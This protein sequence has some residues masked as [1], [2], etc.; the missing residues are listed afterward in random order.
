MGAAAAGERRRRLRTPDPA[1]ALP[2]ASGRVRASGFFFSRHPDP[3]PLGPVSPPGART[4]RTL[5][6]GAAALASPPPC[7]VPGEQRVRGAGGLRHPRRG[8]RAAPVAVAITTPVGTGAAVP[9]WSQIL[10]EGRSRLPFVARSLLAKEGGWGKVFLP[11]CWPYWHG[12][13][14]SHC[15]CGIAVPRRFHVPT[16]LGSPLMSG[17]EPLARPWRRCLCLHYRWPVQL[18][19]FQ[20]PWPGA[21]AHA[22]LSPICAVLV[23][24]S[25]QHVCGAGKWGH[26]APASTSAGVFHSAGWAG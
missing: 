3:Q 6:T 20:E 2:L 25:K 7:P 13:H 22:K 8:A 9:S 21:L 16:A 5:P 18:S 11:Q 14:C 12:W 15:R 4:G 19:W 17:R 10:Q 24:F 23:V 26:A 1:P